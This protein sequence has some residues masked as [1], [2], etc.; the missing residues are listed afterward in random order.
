MLV[1]HEIHRGESKEPA[2][3]VNT[4]LLVRRVTITGSSPQNRATVSGM[5]EIARTWSITV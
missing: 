1:A 3:I 4:G 5:L 2:K